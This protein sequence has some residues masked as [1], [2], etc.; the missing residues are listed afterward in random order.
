M[1]PFDPFEYQE[2]RC[3]SHD[4]KNAMYGKEKLPPD[5]F[6]C[7]WFYE[8]NNLNRDKMKECD[9]ISRI[10]SNIMKSDMRIR[11]KLAHEYYM[12]HMVKYLNEA[13]INTGQEYEKYPVL[14]I[15]DFL[16][17]F[18]NHDKN[19]LQSLQHDFHVITDV[20]DDIERNNFFQW[21]TQSVQDDNDGDGDGEDME[22]ERRKVI[23]H[24]TVDS[25]KK[26]ID[27]KIKLSNAI[28]ILSDR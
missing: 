27:T 5:C 26:L 25:Y 24:K 16:R 23:D 3:T 13:G 12:I 19:M 9:L 15:G 11:C 21:Y 20:T 22:Y 4:H 28:T 17:H 18:E 14:T 6:I 8:E 1:Q 2:G 10:R 7:H